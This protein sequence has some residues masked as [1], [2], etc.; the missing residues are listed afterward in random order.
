MFL[1]NIFSLF[2]LFSIFSI[3]ALTDLVKA[4]FYF[5]VALAAIHFSCTIIFSGGHMQW[6]SIFN[7]TVFLLSKHLHSFLFIGIE[8]IH[9]SSCSHPFDEFPF[10]YYKRVNAA[11][12]SFKF[13]V[14][15]QNRN[16]LVSRMHILKNVCYMT[17]SFTTIHFFYDSVIISQQHLKQS[18]CQGNCLY[19]TII[20]ATIH[21]NERSAVDSR[22]SWRVRLFEENHCSPAVLKVAIYSTEQVAIIFVWKVVKCTKALTEVPFFHGEPA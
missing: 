3:F 6:S 5:K 21:Y 22:K 8:L 10:F 20:F 19:F 1:K 7:G 11:T 14:F 4:D 17:T 12:H 2:F 9:N 18:T 15:L 16:T 13:T